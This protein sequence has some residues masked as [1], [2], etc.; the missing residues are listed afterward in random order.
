MPGVGKPFLLY[1]QRGVESLWSEVQLGLGFLVGL[2]MFSAP[3]SSLNSSSSTFYL[4]RSLGFWRVFLNVPAPYSAIDL[5]CVRLLQTRVF[6][7]AHGPLARVDSCFLLFGSWQPGDWSDWVLLSWP[8]LSLGQTCVPMS[9]ICDFQSDGVPPAH[10]GQTLCVFDW[11]LVE[12]AFNS[13]GI[14]LWAHFLPQG[15]RLFIFTLFLAPVGPLLVLYGR[16]PLPCLLQRLKI[17]FFLME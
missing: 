14:G 4:W 2:V 16:Q 10:G 5:L 13:I 7:Y 17:V 3:P 6:L 11:T 12:E 8:S 15:L 9:L 1:C